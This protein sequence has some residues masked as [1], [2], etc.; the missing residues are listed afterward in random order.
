MEDKKITKP[1]DPQKAFLKAQKYCAYQERS[2]QEVRD[3]LYS[4]G[5]HRKEV[6][7]I[8]T[9]LILQGFLKEE[10]FAHAFAGGKF[11]MKGWGRIKIKLALKQKNVSEIL[12]RQ[13]LKAIDERDYRKMLL[14]ILDEKSKNTTE[15]NPLKRKYKL[16]QYAISRG[17]EPE[18]VWEIINQE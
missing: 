7:N 12:I 2:Q 9:E 11:R 5:L 3:K 15:K 14:K 4:Y 13:A 6:E 16:A 17:F 10:R 8:L 1:I 18:L